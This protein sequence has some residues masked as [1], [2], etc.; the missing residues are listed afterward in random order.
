[1]IEEEVASQSQQN[2][3]QAGQTGDDTAEQISD[4]A[5][6]SH[7]AETLADVLSPVLSWERDNVEFWVQIGQLI[8][9]L[10]ILREVS[11]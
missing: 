7:D 11:S 6:V 10:L 9:L 2:G 3:Q 5:T 4:A 8:V 1:M